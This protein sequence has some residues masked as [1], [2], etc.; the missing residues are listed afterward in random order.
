[1]RE[2]STEQRTADLANHNLWVNDHST[3]ARLDWSDCN[4]RDADLQ[5]AD[6]RYANLRGADLQYADLQYA[7]GLL[8]IGPLGSR[9]DWLDVTYDGD[10]LLFTTGCRYQVSAA[11]F[12]KAVKK[13]HDDNEYARQYKAAIAFAK[14]WYKIEMADND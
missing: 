2:I 5:G 11:E 8:R 9:G 3:G 13:T 12:T 10:G 6:L 1:M 14:A 7:E 4:L